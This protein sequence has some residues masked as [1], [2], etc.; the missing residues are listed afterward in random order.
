MVPAD[1]S[2]HPRR[3][4][5][6]RDRRAG[7]EAS[8][9]LR[10]W[11]RLR[12]LF[13]RPLALQRRGWQW[14]VVL[15]ERRHADLYVSEPSVAEIRLELRD[16]LRAEGEERARQFM[17]HLMVVQRELGRLGWAGVGR[18]PTVVLQ[19]ALQQAELL[20]E[21][22]PGRPMAHLVERLRRFE[23]A[24]RRRDAN[25]SLL[26]HGEAGAIEVSEA[27]PEDFERTERSWFDTLPEA[28]EFKPGG[29]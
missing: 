25:R 24:A 2:S 27:T 10:A 14:H 20:H 3:R 11:R 18:L 16:H 22:R 7:P 17:R 15:L 9:L 1:P 13:A 29:S 28:P 21:R 8:A 12:G 6:R 26:A 23:S 5:V 19:R 4:R